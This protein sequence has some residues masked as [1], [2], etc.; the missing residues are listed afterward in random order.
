VILW[1]C[2]THD[3]KKHTSGRT[4]WDIYFSNEITGT[5]YVASACHVTWTAHKG[6]PPGM[7]FPCGSMQNSEVKETATG[8][9]VRSYS[10]EMGKD[11]EQK[12]FW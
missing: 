10:T 2:V 4:L 5:N 6:A 8:T 9:D 7:E 1:F 11:M 12:S 3:E